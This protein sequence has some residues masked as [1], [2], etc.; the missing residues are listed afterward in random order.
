M[1]Y[2]QYAFLSSIYETSWICSEEE[3]KNLF[4]WKKRKAELF[5][6]LCFQVFYKRTIKFIVSLYILNL[7]HFV[8][9]T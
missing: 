2:P 6:D 5:K 8:G 7:F 4:F 1:A 9:S 3:K